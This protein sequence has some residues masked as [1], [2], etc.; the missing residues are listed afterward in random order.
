MI[1]EWPLYDCKREATTLVP[2]DYGTSE[3]VGL[4]DEH[5]AKLD[6]TFPPRDQPKRESP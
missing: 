2:L 6:E 3:I 5:F 4:C 1:C